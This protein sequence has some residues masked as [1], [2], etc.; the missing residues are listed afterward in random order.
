MAR[1][2]VADKMPTAIK[3][4]VPVVVDMNMGSN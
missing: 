2:I 3:L 4:D 1:Q